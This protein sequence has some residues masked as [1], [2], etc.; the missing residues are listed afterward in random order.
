MTDESESGWLRFECTEGTSRKFWEVRQEGSAYRV[1]YGRIGTRGREERKQL[2]SAAACTRAV[3]AKIEEKRRKGYVGQGPDPS[4]LWQAVAKKDEA[5]IRRLLAAGADPNESHDGTCLLESAFENHAGDEIAL[6]LLDAG[7]DPARLSSNHLNLVWA[8]C[9]GRADVVRAFVRAGAPLDRQAIMGGPLEVAASR[10][11]LE[12]LDLLIEA[13]ADV[14]SGSAFDSP[15]SSAVKRGQPACALRLLEAGA[16]LDPK[17][18]GNRRV[19]TNAAKAGMADVLR[20]LAR[21][22]ADLE[23]RASY[24]AQEEGEPSYSQATALMMAAGE[25]H[26]ACV[27]A[28]IEAGVDLDALDDQG[29][30]AVDHARLRGHATIAE[31]LVAAGASSQ[32]RRPPELRLLLA[33]EAGDMAALREALAAGAPVDTRDA[34]GVQ[35]G[36]TALMLASA[37]GHAALVEALLA[38]GADARRA[39]D[40]G[41]EEPRR[42]TGQSL[43]NDSRGR[44]ALMLAAEGGHAEIVR[45]LLAAGADPAHE[46]HEKDTALL[47][48]ARYGHAEVVRA[49]LEVGADPDQ[50]G[51]ALHQCFEHAAYAPAPL[52][53]DAGARLDRKNADGETIL[54]SAALMGQADLV[55]RLLEAGANPTA[56]NRQGELPREHTR[57]HEI[58]RLLEAAERDWSAKGRKRAAKP[59]DDDPEVARARAARAPTPKV[60]A[61]S[62]KAL[63]KTYGQERVLARLRKAAEAESFRAL[64]PEI[65]EA[66]GSQ[67][68]DQRTDLGGYLFHVRTGRL[69]LDGL[70]A[71]QAR[72]LERGALVVCCGHG[73]PFGSP[74]RLLALPTRDRYDALAVLGTNGVNED[75]SPWDIIR[76]LMQREQTQPFS[77]FWV[78]HST[79]EGRFHGPIADPEELAYSMYD[80]CSD[81]VDQGTETVEALADSLART[82][83]LYFWWD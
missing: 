63:E 70:A 64:L 76:W 9:T 11:C 15:L 20:A 44:T 54:H 55:Q 13:G 47:L 74:G 83:R 36:R 73:T 21:T 42:L 24:S 34:R 7:A 26:A 1:R 77:L 29:Q 75:K 4:E 59:E 38:A 50:C 8:T 27:E 12:I 41:E 5:R 46:D 68:E 14:N 18:F 22:G 79:L 3:Q 69:D 49:L 37:R 23:Q 53:I 2:D 51:A 33:A 61:P 80:L 40:D 16:T 32:A 25:G 31:R 67:P 45:R 65:A 72:L 60:R 78:E 35:L 66:C 56:R 30:S 81:I 6:A 10:G 48:A 52:L 58:Q 17:L 28:L 71:L 57:S 82:G 43:G 39:D 19:A 62:A